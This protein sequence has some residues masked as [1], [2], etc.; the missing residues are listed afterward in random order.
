MSRI[1]LQ[2]RTT[3]GL[4]HIAKK[5]K[6]RNSSSSPSIAL[7]HTFYALSEK[8]EV[9]V[10]PLSQHEGEACSVGSIFRSLSYEFFAF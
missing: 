10:Q 7:I 9:R 4:R 1:L 5:T 6:T 8:I 3:M 2:P